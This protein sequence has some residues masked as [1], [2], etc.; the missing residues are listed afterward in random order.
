MA[1]VHT[2]VISKAVAEGLELLE[3]LAACPAGAA[4]E[5]D[6]YLLRVPH[7]LPR[8]KAVVF[9][10]SVKAGAVFGVQHGHAYVVAR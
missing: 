4:T 10:R 6:R 8:A 7:W 2:D 3:R 5:E 9:A 1:A